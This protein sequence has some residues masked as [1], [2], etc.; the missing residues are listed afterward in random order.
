MEA[1]DKNLYNEQSMQINSEIKDCLLTTA[2]WANFLA[3]VGYI[4][5]GFMLIGALSLG[6]MSSQLGAMAGASEVFTWLPLVYL[7][8]AVLYFFPVYYLHR[9]ATN[10]KR[11]LNANNESALTDGMRYLKSHY[12]YLGICVI[13]V[14][15]IYAILFM[16]MIIG[17]IAK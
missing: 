1:V 4:G 9:F 8:I 16:V 15:G 5:L 3:I 11:A 17:L 7:L 13:V 14:L 12:K 10:T 6:A 2:K